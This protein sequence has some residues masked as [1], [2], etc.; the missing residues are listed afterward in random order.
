MPLGEG[1]NRVLPR[2]ATSRSVGLV[3]PVAEEELAAAALRASVSWRAA[4]AAA[5]SCERLQRLDAGVERAVLVLLR[6]RVRSSTRRPPAAG[7]QV[8]DGVLEPRRVVPEVA[9]QPHQHALD[10]GLGHPPPRLPLP[11][12]LAAPQRRRV[13]GRDRATSGAAGCRSSTSTSGSRCRRPSCLVSPRTPSRRGAPPVAP[14]DPRPL[15]RVLLRP[16]PDRRIALRQPL[17]A[18]SGLV[19]QPQRLQPAAGVRRGA[20]G[21]DER[22]APG[23]W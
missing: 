3:E 7:R 15:R 8:G 21:H 14:R 13:T 17:R 22:A 10:A 1:G 9:G 6:P 18:T 2:T 5:Y 20:H 19:V 16:P 4:R 12:P 23:R 11:E